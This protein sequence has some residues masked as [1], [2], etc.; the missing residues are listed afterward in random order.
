MSVSTSM[1]ATAGT[2]ESAGAQNVTRTQNEEFTAYL[3]EKMGLTSTQADALLS[4]MTPDQVAKFLT[5]T[6]KKDTMTRE[7]VMEMSTELGSVLSEAD[8]A[9]L[10]PRTIGTFSNPFGDAF[11]NFLI[12]S[13]SLGTDIRQLMAKT[14]QAQVD[15]VIQK[16]E[17]FF[18]GAVVQFACAMTAALVTGLSAGMNVYQA[19]QS[20]DEALDAAKTAK[21]EDTAS[22]I[23]GEPEKEATV[24]KSKTSADTTKS[25][26]QKDQSSDDAP[27]AAEQKTTNVRSAADSMWFGPIGASLLTQPITAAGEFGNAF[28]QREGAYV[29]ADEQ[30]IRALYEQLV[31]FY[32]TVNDSSHSLAQSL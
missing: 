8:I 12:L 29:E 21:V 11:L 3:T 27:N 14:L 4:A 13:Y 6:K 23:R 17:E 26:A 16:A 24:Q 22:L 15:L 20:R 7:E 32:Q 10:F 1:N 2:Y 25:D 9:V 5:L 18:K 31:T 28:Y 19:K 30:E